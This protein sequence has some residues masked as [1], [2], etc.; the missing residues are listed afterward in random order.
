MKLRTMVKL[1]YRKALPLRRNAAKKKGN[2]SMA[3][4]NYEFTGKTVDE[5]VAEGLKTLKLRPDQVDIEVLNKGSRGIFGIGSE[6]AQVH[7]TPRTEPVKTEVS[8]KT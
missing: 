6:P 5:A 7:V 4:Q 2:R 3:A 1:P 8:T